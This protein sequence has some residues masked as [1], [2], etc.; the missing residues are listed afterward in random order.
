MN[1]SLQEVC[2]ACNDSPLS[3]TGNI[4]GLLTFALGLLASCVAFLSIVR[5]ADSEIESLVR[6]TNETKAHIVKMSIHIGK[7]GLRQN[8][9]DLKDMY[10]LLTDCLAGFAKAQNSVAK[11]LEM[12]RLPTSLW[13]RVKW[14]Y[15]EKE[16]AAQMAKLDSYNQ[17]ITALQLTFLLR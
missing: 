13:T 15:M 8:S 16:T 5:N 12:F 11:H 17:R 6:D 14:W 2:P 7:L 10:D 3:F 4:V 1:C 9:P